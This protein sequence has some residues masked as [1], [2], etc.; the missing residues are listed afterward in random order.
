VWDLQTG[1]PAGP[2]RDGWSW[3]APAQPVGFVGGAD[4]LV[5]LDPDGR[6]LTRLEVGGAGAY[7]ATDLDVRLPHRLATSPST[8]LVAVSNGSGSIEIWDALGQAR[9]RVIAS[10]ADVVRLQLSADGK[11]LAAACADDSVRLWD[12]ETGF[13]LGPPL[14]HP[15]PVAALAFS[16]DGRE[17]TAALRSG[18]LCR[19]PLPGPMAGSAA[20]C[21]RRLQTRLG[22]V[23]GSG[24]GALLDPEAWA[25]LR[26]QA[27]APGVE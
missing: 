7:R 2:L 8:R 21:E 26:R 5:V 10:A 25:A 9:Q 23:Y 19:W 17:L 12:M 22:I 16:R 18:R 20:A 15:S 27:P 1:K 24:G 3:W 13:P 14:C 4:T 11:T 6:K